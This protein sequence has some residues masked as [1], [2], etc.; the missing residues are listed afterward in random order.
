MS[1]NRRGLFISFEGIDGCGK[2]TQVM[3]VYKYLI[4]QGRQV[5]LVREPGSTEA[6][7]RIR[8]LLLDRRLAIDERTE[9]LLYEAARADLAAREIA[10]AL[11]RGLVVLCDR[12]YDSTTAYQGF[13]R[14]LDVAMVRALH[15]VAV[16]DLEPDL[17]LV[18]DCDIRTAM[19]RRAGD[20]D[21]LEAESRAFFERVR[22]GFLEIARK[23]RRRVK[24]IDAAQP[25]ETVFA[26]VK[27]H[28]VRKLRNHDA[29]R[30]P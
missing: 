25:V 17:T 12:F 23:E 14:R 6:A 21:R 8:A 28:L 5:K 30:R 10:P 26:D 29:E 4:A 27:K 1:K 16:D 24:V 20:P 7:E 19:G 15:R 11:A 18:F 22:K 2:T 9:L 3:L 13:G